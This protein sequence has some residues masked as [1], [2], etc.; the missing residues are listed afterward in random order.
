MNF[1]GEDIFYSV[2]GLG[3]GV[4][5]LREM[6]RSAPVAGDIE[7]PTLPPTHE[8]TLHREIRDTKLTRQLKQLYHNKCQVCGKVIKLPGQEYSEAHHLK[9]LGRPHS[10]PDVPGNVIVV[11]PDHHAEFD[12]GAIAVEPVTLKIMHIVSDNPVV[13]QRLD[14]HPSHTLDAKYL[15]YH[16]ETIFGID[17]RSEND[18]PQ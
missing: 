10:G 3:K 11:C 4:W 5:G 1:R 17:R 8:V 9:P 13:G 14:L 15:L 7:K 12:F 18:T 6:L 2:E 16:L